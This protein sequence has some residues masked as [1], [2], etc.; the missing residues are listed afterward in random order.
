MAEAEGTFDALWD[1][2]WESRLLERGMAK[3]RQYYKD[4][5]T[6]EAFERAFVLNQEPEVVAAELGMSRES[7]YQAKTRVLARLRVEL[8]GI[9]EELGE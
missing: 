2:E 3:V 5:R 6:F 7:V 8:E 9:G 4:G 1:A